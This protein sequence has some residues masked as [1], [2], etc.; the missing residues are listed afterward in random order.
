MSVKL[1]LDM[2]LLWLMLGVVALVLHGWGNLTWRFLGV[3]K[4][5]T[6]S[7]LTV[8]LGFCSV[9]LV[10]ETVHLMF[11][12]DWKVSLVV[13]IVGLV[14]VRIAR[15][16]FGS[17][18]WRVAGRW[19]RDRPL[20]AA[21]LVAVFCFWSLRAMEI[22]LNYDSGLYHF[23]SIR[24]LNEEP[25]VLGLANLHWRLALNQSYFGFIALLN[26]A[27]Y[28]NKGY[29]ASG[30]LLLLLT[31]IT[32]YQVTARSPVIWRCVLFGLFFV[33]LNQL[34]GSVSNPAPDFAVMLL[35][36]VIF[37][38]L[39][40]FIAGQW[41]DNELSQWHVP[42]L[43]LL[44]LSIVTVKLSSVAYAAATV[45]LTTYR[46]LKLKPEF[47]TMFVR[48]FGILTFCSLIHVVR[49]LL[50]SGVPLFPSAISGFWTLPWA[51]PRG[52][53][54]FESALIYAWAREP[55][56]ST[57]PSTHRDLLAWLG[58]WLGALPITWVCT[59]VLATVLSCLNGYFF[60]QNVI[61]KQSTHLFLLYVPI[62]SAFIF[63]FITAPDVRFLGAVNVLYLA[64]SIALLAQQLSDKKAVNDVIEQLE[65]RQ[66][67]FLSVGAPLA[68]LLLVV[69]MSRWVIIQ[70]LSFVGWPPLT[71]IKVK[72]IETVSGFSVHV[73]ETGEQC[74][75]SPL[76]CATVVYG[77][78]KKVGLQPFDSLPGLVNYR[79]MLT[80]K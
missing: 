38:Y 37:L 67:K 5:S 33:Y 7:A 42:V 23:G 77:S 41:S 30:L 10:L 11:P 26:I 9:L 1:F 51:I 44:S 48:L 19:L 60:I 80:V 49:S 35:E 22:P 27:P 24:W 74:W 45:V 28:W 29:A 20:Y 69:L 54:E 56:I 39:Y 66:A 75:D 63:W 62:L 17:D 47:G 12:I 2:T 61:K 13:L 76:P 79:Y 36:I 25:I 64:L 59:F 71:Q 72:N 57:I 3:E 50:L 6:S 40:E 46:V 65:I 32:L 73:P 52:I 16:R 8:W 70:P 68:T 78:L 31:A 43:M 21:L 34:A 15:P 55:S 53:V 14:G 4:P 58:V 18:K